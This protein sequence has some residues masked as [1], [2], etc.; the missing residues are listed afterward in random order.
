[1]HHRPAAGVDAPA[2]HTHAPVRVGESLSS[3]AVSLRVERRLHC[4]DDEPALIGS[5]ELPPATASEPPAVHGDADDTGA[6]PLVAIDTTSSQWDSSS[7]ND[8]SGSAVKRTHSGVLRAIDTHTCCYHA[9]AWLCCLNRTGAAAIAISMLDPEPDNGGNGYTSTAI[10][11][12]S[13]GTAA[14]GCGFSTNGWRM[15]W[16]LLLCCAPWPIAFGGWYA[17]NVRDSL[18]LPWYFMWPPSLLAVAH[19]FTWLNFHVYRPP[20]NVLYESS[21]GGADPESFWHTAHFVLVAFCGV[22][23]VMLVF[24]FC[25]MRYWEA[26]LLGNGQPVDAL[27]AWGAIATVALAATSLVCRVREV[28]LLDLEEKARRDN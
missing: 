8:G 26:P 5:R 25:G 24:L 2:A 27:P 11:G 28:M 10:D 13:Y 18:S 16:M 17:A 21:G 15:A 19:F 1:M 23:G 20:A 12:V 7:T 3:P 6:P 22:A 9:C 14:P 4:D